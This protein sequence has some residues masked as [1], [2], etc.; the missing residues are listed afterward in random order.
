MGTELV[1]WEEKLRNEAKDVAKLERPSTSRI[2][3][4]SGM[5]AIGDNAIPG[6]TLDCVIIG[7]VVFN[8]FFKSP[9]VEGVIRAPDCYAISRTG[10]NMVPHPSLEEPQAEACDRC[11][12]SRFNTAG[13]FKEDDP[14]NGRKGKACGV[15]RREIALVP[16]YK[17]SK[18]FASAEMATAGL[19]FMSVANWAAYVNGLSVGQERPYYGVVTR[20]SVSPDRQ[21]QFKVK[22]EF[23]RKLTDEEMGILYPKIETAYNILE[24]ARVVT[25]DAPPAEQPAADTKKK[26]F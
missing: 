15:G 5:M 21:A 2:S 16:A 18:D 8:S 10:E 12:A 6:N 4:K 13:K 1:N 20:M 22:F 9:Y 23:V 11:W 3:F 17:E 19:P 26:K 14:G 25:S 7:S 24:A